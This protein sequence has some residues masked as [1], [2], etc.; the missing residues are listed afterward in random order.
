MIQNKN[1]ARVR[2]Y[3][4]IL[5]ARYTSL[6]SVNDRILINFYRSLNK[7]NSYVHSMNDRLLEKTLISNKNKQLSEISIRNKIF[8]IDDYSNFPK[9]QL[10]I[11]QI[12]I[13][14]SN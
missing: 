2:E 1:T 4:N 6:V 5:L 8:Q 14:S 3:T 11:F 9:L 7:V 13:L 10:I 12:T